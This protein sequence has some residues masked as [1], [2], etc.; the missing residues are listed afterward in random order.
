MYIYKITN[1]VNG[2]LYIGQT[3]NNF[4]TRY[5][6]SFTKS[7]HS[8]DLKK[9]INKYGIDNFIINKELDIATTQEELD[10][11][12]QYWINYYDAVNPLCGYNKDYGGLNGKRGEETKERIRQGLLN[13]HKNRKIKCITTGEIFNNAREGAEKYNIKSKSQINTCCNGKCSFCGRLE[14]GT[15]LVWSYF[16][17]I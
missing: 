7:T 12:E 10:L 3:K 8:L 2:R 14:D 4:K 11:K 9:D 5:M 17:I 1:M 16:Y 6:G 15:K 13:K